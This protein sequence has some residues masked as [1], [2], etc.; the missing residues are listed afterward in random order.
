MEQNGTDVFCCRL[1]WGFA[2]VGRYYNSV[3]G[4]VALPE[5]IRVLYV[6]VVSVGRSV[7]VVTFNYLILIA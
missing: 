6:V 7:R 2:V 5:A 4:N 3:A 1:V